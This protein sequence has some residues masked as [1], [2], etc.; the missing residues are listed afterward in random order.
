M[1]VTEI[2]SNV[3]FPIFVCLYLVKNN[4]KLISSLNQL[5]NTLETMNIRLELLERNF[6]NE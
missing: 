2:I 1:D 5:S 3:G 4:E 6:K